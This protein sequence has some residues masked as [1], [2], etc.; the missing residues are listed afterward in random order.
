MS[1][2]KS[3]SGG[4]TLVELLV[5]LVVLVIIFMAFSTS[6]S[7]IQNLNKTAG[8]IATANEL[9]FAK[10]EQYENKPFGNLPATTP[11]GTLVQVEDFT[12]SLPTSLQNPRSAIVYINSVSSTLKQVVVNI[13]YGNN[14]SQKHVIEYADFIQKNG[15]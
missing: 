15:L 3:S 11:T 13:Q 10:I 1:A 2:I 12:S 14:A 8:D 6:F 7:T 9:A 5:M 4:F